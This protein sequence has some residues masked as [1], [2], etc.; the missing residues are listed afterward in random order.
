MR[1]F[2]FCL[3]AACGSGGGFPDARE[4]D[5]PP[6]TGTFTLDWALT[7]LANNN[8]TCDQVGAQSVTVLAHNQAVEGGLT[9]VFVCSTLMGTSQGLEPGIYDFDFQL[10]AASG[11]LQAPP[12]QHT[13]TIASGQNTRLA[14]L[15]FQL[16]ATGG[17]ALTLSTGRTTNCGTAT[18]ANG[19]ITQETITLTHNSDSS[20]EPI[21]LAI[22]ASTLSPPPAS[23]SG[24]YTINC[25]T[26]MVTTCIE[27]DSTVTATG[28]KADSY[29][30]HVA[31]KQGVAG[32]SGVCWTNSDSIVIPPLGGTL[33]RQLNLGFA[34]A[35]T[36]CM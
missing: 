4:I 33:T 15:A 14:A 19:A 21:T 3:L 12:G 30:I 26:P 13:I 6:P 35:N 25:A 34:T 2:S 22:S 20:C 28:V 36:S 24:S 31:G 17:V 16:D 8:I 18:P 1:A 29:T 23:A 11:I 10:A 5:A 9:Q 32:A 27:K 7:D